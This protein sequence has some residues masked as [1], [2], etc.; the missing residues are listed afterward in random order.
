MANLIE[1]RNG[2]RGDD[3]PNTGNTEKRTG[4][5]PPERGEGGERSRAGNQGR[6]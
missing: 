2:T 4:T 3:A 1:D 6:P 5:G